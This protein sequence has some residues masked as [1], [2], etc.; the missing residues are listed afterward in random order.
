MDNGATYTHRSNLT[1]FNLQ[2]LI[3][4]NWTLDLA[5]GRLFTNLK[6]DANGRP[7]RDETVDKIYDASSIVTTPVTVFNP[8][9]SI[10]YVLPGNGLFNNGGITPLWHDHYV[11]EI[12]TKYKFNYFS[13]NKKHFVTF[14]QEHKEQSLQ[15]A[16]VT[17]PWVGAPIKLADGTF[18]QSRSIGTGSD[19]WRVKP[20]TG[21][22]YA[23]DE[24]RYKGI[25]AVVGARLEY[26]APGKFAD[27]SVENPKA[28][29]LES[30]R[31]DYR[32]Q[33]TKFLGRRWKAR[34]LPKLRVSFPVTE[35]N[36][37]Y[38]N[39]GHSMRLPHPR[40]VYAG[41]DP[42]YQDRS[43]LSNL[44]NPNLNPEVAVSY[45]LGVKSQIT[46][47]F[48]VTFTAFY[49]DYF[50]FIVNRNVNFPGD[51]SSKAF[52]INQDYARI[53]GLEVMLNY[54]FNKSLRANFNA[55][56]QVATGKSNTAAESRLQIE[57]NG[58]VDATKEQFLAW[59]RPFDLKGA[60]IYTPD[61][62]VVLFNVP[63]KGFRFFFTSTFKSGMR[64]TP[65]R[66][67]GYN[68]IGRPRY[69][70][71]P[72]QPN[73]KIGSSW[74]W[75]DLKITRD[76]RMGRKKFVSFSVEINNIFNNKNAQIINPVTGRAYQ[77]GDNVTYTQRDPRYP[78][79]QDS[80][81]PPNNPAR[82][83]QP[84]QVIYGISFSF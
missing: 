76:F 24:I 79:P 73:S 56:Y 22:F 57:K 11:R 42:V 9:D 12:T 58:S 66:I 75:S 72:T 48:G 19:V 37:L 68:E 29:V 60:V 23:Q 27:E 5:V 63:L 80:G 47:D 7:F 45:E 8:G 25:S 81:L 34:L 4:K 51:P 26:W 2:Q 31:E 16:D 13:P 71:I 62:S 41:L 61:T 6:A 39:Y 32:N 65:Q 46:R 30:I 14:G 59:D 55:G 36:V 74:F 3:N 44:G 35:N 82:Y 18:I 20:A 52:S 64:Y 77:D 69:E 28:P 10:S 33:T 70:P 53:R 38:F 21:G 40:F 78:N 54:R 67:N 84:R 1:V 17:S 50:D 43:A 49:K 83:L 15:W